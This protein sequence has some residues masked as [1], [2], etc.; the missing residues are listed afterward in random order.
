M[1]RDPLLSQQMADLQ[2]NVLNVKNTF[3]KY[4]W[5]KLKT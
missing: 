5:G 4:K 1:L 3:R 2:P